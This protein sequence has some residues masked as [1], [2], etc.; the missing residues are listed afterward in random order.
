GAARAPALAI[1]RFAFSSA[2]TF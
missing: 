1:D 2:T